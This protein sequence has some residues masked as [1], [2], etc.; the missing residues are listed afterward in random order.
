MVKFIKNELPKV[1]AILFKA[2]YSVEQVNKLLKIKNSE[3]LLRLWM[4]S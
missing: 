1:V 3:E 4:I 2:G